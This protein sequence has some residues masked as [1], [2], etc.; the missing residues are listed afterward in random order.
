M[1]ISLHIKYPVFMSDFNQCPL[2]MLDFIQTQIFSTDFKKILV[3]NF[4]KIRPVGAKLFL[5][6]RRTD[7]HDK[8]NSCYLQVCE[9]T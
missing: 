1:C 6:V 5:V 8:A 9:C 3:S 7:K 2:F 4:M